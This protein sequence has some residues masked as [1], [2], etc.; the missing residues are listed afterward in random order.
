LRVLT[1]SIQPSAEEISA[2]MAVDCSG[3]LVPA[4]PLESH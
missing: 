1:A 4:P 2:S 3:K